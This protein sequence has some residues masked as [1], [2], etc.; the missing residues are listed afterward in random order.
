MI[1]HP[2]IFVCVEL[3]EPRELLSSSPTGL[4]PHQVRHAYGFDRIT[5]PVH[6]KNIHAN[7]NGQTIAI[8]DAYDA[9]NIT[10]DLKTF[11]KAFNLPD[12]DMK[13]K[14]VL[15]K[16]VPGATP[17]VD[18]GW[19]GEIS[20]DV[21]WAHAIAP[22]AH[23]LLVEAASASTS[24][25]LD[26]I[27]YARKQPGVVAVSMSWGGDESPFETYYD[28][29][30]TTPKG[31]VGGSGIK[32]GVTFVTSSGDNGAPAAWPAVS[33]NVIAVGGTT[34]SINSKNNWA[35]ES[36]W[37]G[38]GGGLSIYEP[39]TT[40]APDVAY[41]ADPQ[42]GF[43]IY[44]ST[45]QQGVSGWLA[46]GGT[47]AGAPQWA[48]LVALVDQGRELAGAG[49]LNTTQALNS[50]YSIKAGDFHDITTGYNGYY[51]GPGYDLVTGRGTPIASS[52]V[53]DLI[54]HTLPAKLLKPARGSIFQSNRKITA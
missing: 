16:A 5:Y 36:A 22:R 19:A 15:T 23:I 33:P 37:A 25:L 13:G 44:D 6:G 45:P 11:D 4:S 8:V 39:Y 24:D 30:L 50:L 20:L 34:L 28:N 17:P 14:F 29:Y 40:H 3:L 10:N 2:F 52:L 18:A 32:G 49:S 51:A 7:G 42:S 35:G 43:S 27:N 48:G 9:P 54:T 53:P 12:T 47:S 26:A 21:E 31:H 38:S 1:R 41:D 46:I